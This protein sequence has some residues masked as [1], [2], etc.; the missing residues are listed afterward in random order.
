VRSRPLAL[1]ASVPS[2]ARP[3]SLVAD[4]YEPVGDLGVAEWDADDPMTS[5]RLGTLARYSS[6]LADY[7]AVRRRSRPHPRKPAPR[8]AARTAA[9]GTT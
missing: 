3:V 9:T 8:A 6:I 4:F 2:E 1:K 5:S 7:E